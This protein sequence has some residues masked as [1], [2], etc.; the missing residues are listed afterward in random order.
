[1]II[2]GIVNIPNWI[3]HIIKKLRSNK[4][5]NEKFLFV[6]EKYDYHLDYLISVFCK[7]K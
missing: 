6:V 4:M 3:L 5:N 1:M 2:N 7:L